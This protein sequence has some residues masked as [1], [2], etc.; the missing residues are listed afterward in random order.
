MSKE[1]LYRS[2]EALQLEIKKLGDGQDDVKEGLSRLVADLEHQLENPEDTAHAT[3][4]LQNLPD[5]IE[6]FEVEHPR[7]TSILN[8]IMMTLSNMGI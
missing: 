4:L 3:S 5:H 6:Q 1:D 8:H 2:L 7:M